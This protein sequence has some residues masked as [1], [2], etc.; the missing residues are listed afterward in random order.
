MGVGHSTGNG[1]LDGVS[2]SEDS[3]DDDLQFAAEFPKLNTAAAPMPIPGRQFSHPRRTDAALAE[4][5]AEGVSPVTG[6]AAAAEQGGDGGGGGAKKGKKKKGAQGAGANSSPSRE[7]ALAAIEV[8]LQAGAAPGALSC[9]GAQRQPQ[10]APPTGCR[11]GTWGKLEFFS[12]TWTLR[13]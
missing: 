10:T 1:H 5:V 3:D 2:S 7:A 9:A 13:L 8:A 12:W 11:T 6:T 4:P